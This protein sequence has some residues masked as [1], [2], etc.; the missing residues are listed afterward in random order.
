MEYRCG[1][2]R[3]LKEKRKRRKGR[4]E[5]ARTLSDVDVAEN[6]DEDPNGKP[7]DGCGRI[8]RK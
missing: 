7:G 8:G 6:D 5:R 3:E 1:E 2:V 4:A